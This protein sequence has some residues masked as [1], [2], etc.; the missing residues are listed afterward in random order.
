MRWLRS[1]SQ[2]Q[3]TN[4]TSTSSPQPQI[5]THHTQLTTQPSTHPPAPNPQP[6]S[7]PRRETPSNTAG[8]AAARGAASS[9]SSACCSTVTSS[10]PGLCSTL[11]RAARW[12]RARN[13]RALCGLRS[14]LRCATARRAARLELPS[15]GSPGLPQ[16]EP[17]PP[18]ARLR[19]LRPRLLL[20]RDD[21]LA[22][23]LVVRVVG[24]LVRSH[25]RD[26]RRRAL[27]GLPCVP[28]HALVAAH[29]EQAPPPPPR[30]LVKE[31]GV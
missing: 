13:S 1:S 15:V 4:P 7:P 9:T 24:R 10:P 12:G 31:E 6:P 20:G 19:L 16:R 8:L 18:P 11:E 22:R 3:V 21:D 29:A 5:Q 23:V 30:D 28:R 27:R 14:C 26:V 17:R 2:T 25:A